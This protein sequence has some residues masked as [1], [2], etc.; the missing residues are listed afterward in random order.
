M[1]REQTRCGAVC[2][3]IDFDRSGWLAMC[4]GGLLRNN[5]TSGSNPGLIEGKVKCVVINR[6]GRPIGNRI[7]KVRVSGC[8][9]Q[10]FRS[11]LPSG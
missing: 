9:F 10:N 4:A 7:G 8:S 3:Q 6:V 1:E 2:G 11:P 5:A